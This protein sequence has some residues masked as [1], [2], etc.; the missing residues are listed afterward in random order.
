MMKHIEIHSDIYAHNEKSTRLSIFIINENGHGG[1]A[2]IKGP[3]YNVFLPI[4]EV[5]VNLDLKQAKELQ[6]ELEKY[7]AE[8][9]KEVNHET[10]I[11]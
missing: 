8:L 3:K 2:R 9:W 7:I 1:G 4:K 6:N 10:I 5:K 11:S